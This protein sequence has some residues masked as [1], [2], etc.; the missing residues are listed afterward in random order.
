VKEERL[1]RAM[2]TQDWY[3][4]FPDC[5]LINIVADRSDDCPILLKLHCNN[6][7]NGTKTFK[8][9]NSWLLEEGLEDVVL[10]GWNKQLN[11]DVLHKLKN[12]TDEMNE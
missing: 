11:H 5:Q 1:D 3:D 12:C 7:M 9:E 4:A 10:G 8:F 2:A 6:R